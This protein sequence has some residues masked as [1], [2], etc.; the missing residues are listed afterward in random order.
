MK[1]VL[2]VAPQF[3]PCNLA[4]VHRSRLFAAHLPKFGWGVRV[5]SVAPEYYEEPLDRELEQLLPED[6]DVVRTPAL[7]TRPVRLIGDISLRSIWWHYKEIARF[8][9]EDSV[10]LLYLPIPPN[11]SATLGP[12]IY[13]RYRI[14]YAIDYIDPW[15]H[16]WPGCDV[17]LSRAWLSLRLG[18]MLEPIVLKHAS[19]VTAVAPGYYE[20]AL[21]RNPFLDRSRCIAMPYGAEE[22]DFRFLDEHPRQPT[23]FDPA[24][25]NLHIVYAGA[26]LP[27][28]YST[29]ESVLAAIRS[30]LDK[31][32]EFSR[33]RLHFIGTGSVPSDPSSYMVKPW[34]DRAGLSDFVRESPARIP[35]L[36]VLNHLKH[37]HAVLVLGS[38]EPHYT[39]SKIFQAVLSRR[40]VIA[41]LHSASTGAAILKEA[42]AGR[43][44]TFDEKEPVDRHV[45]EI[46]TAFNDVLHGA[47][48]YSPERVNWDAFRGYS[49]E[50]MA[51]K[52]ACAFDRVVTNHSL[53]VR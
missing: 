13:R 12:L 52:L 22:A 42:N 5:L 16:S 50:A 2:I 6:L 34:V 45:G 49:A 48:G 36:E 4:A 25:G 14:P 21:G 43:L 37:A 40:P 15:V 29:L 1:R 35:Y 27:R 20:G 44:V 10:D 53:I 30:G 31:N 8:I 23:L 28:A 19:L 18:Q 24:D 26:M 39:P 38:S 3:P 9:R 32:R 11:Y 33:L 51:E 41:L 47:T 17:A 46:A 7:S